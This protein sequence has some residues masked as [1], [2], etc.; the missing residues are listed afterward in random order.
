MNEIAS[1]DSQMVFMEKILEDCQALSVRLVV[2]PGLFGEMTGNSSEYI[3]EVIRLS[4]SFNSMIICPGSYFEHSDGLTYHSSCLI[5]AG[6]VGLSQ[7]Q[8]YLANWEREAGLSRGNTLETVSFE[9]FK[10]GI[11]LTTD[12][13]YPQVSRQFAFLGTDIIAA[14]AAITGYDSPL[15]QLS[16]VWQNVQMNLFYAVESGIKSVIHGKSFSSL[17]AIHAP[18]EATEKDNGLL[19]IEKRNCTS[20]I[21]TA[22]LDYNKRLEAIRKFN[23]LKQLNRDFCSSVFEE[24][25]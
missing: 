9:D 2:F 14:P 20:N 5:N 10:V 13:F 12:A 7:R 6:T 4:R 17:S 11:M 16:G 21:I 24:F 19:N 1:L 23:T 25:M 8:V 22:E 3:N 18:L 15:K